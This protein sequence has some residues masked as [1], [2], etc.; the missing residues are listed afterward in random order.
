[1]LD[2]MKKPT[3]EKIN[4]AITSVFVVPEDFDEQVKH[5]ELNIIARWDGCTPESIQSFK[6]RGGDLGAVWSK[7]I[8]DLH[9]LKQ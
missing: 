1:M 6:R 8:S 3:D 2:I 5:A 7:V 4:A 9:N